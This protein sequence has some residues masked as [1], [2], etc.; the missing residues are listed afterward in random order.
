MV[1]RKP[2]VKFEL[3]PVEEKDLDVTLSW[4][5]D[6]EVLKSAKTSNKISIEEHRAM[7]LYNNAIKLI[8]L[9]DD[10]PT[11]YVQFTRDP[12]QAL[13]EWSFHF[14]SDARGKGLSEIMLKA[15]LYYIKKEE[16]Y[17]AVT[18]V[19]QKHNTISNHLHKKLGFDLVGDKGN[20]FE[21]DLAL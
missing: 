3:R 1:H 18:S 17:I 20:F 2:L 4:R 13:G 6:P 14:S 7:F 8:F 19:V 11:G 5:N 21:Y 16:G 10:T 15:A 9:V 12:D